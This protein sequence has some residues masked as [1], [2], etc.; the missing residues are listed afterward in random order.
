MQIVETLI[1]MYKAN[2]GFC[3]L[4]AFLISINQLS[5]HAQ[6]NFE[7]KASYFQKLLREDKWTC[8]QIVSYFLERAFAYDPN[9]RTIISYNPK[10]FQ[11]ADDLDTYYSRNKKF[12]GRMHCVPMTIKDNIDVSDIPTTGGLNALRYSIPRINALVIDRLIAQGAVILGK[13]NMAPLAWG[14]PV[15]SDQVGLC[16]NPFDFS[17][18]CSVSSSGSGA[19]IA[20]GLAI[21]SL[22]TDT[23]TSIVS[24]ASR[25]GVYGLR[26]PHDPKLLEGVLPLFFEHG[27]Q[28][29]FS[30]YY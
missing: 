24:P 27:K 16:Q 11:R 21:V 15:A 12:V 5:T 20:A 26:P 30:N 17:R 3:L 2:F 29:F 28:I 25:T 23:R 9:L 22:G 7:F 10:V 6:E 13:A 14:E 8:R 1:K 18:T 4:T 19:A